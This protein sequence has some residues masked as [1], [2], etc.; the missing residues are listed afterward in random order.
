[1]QRYLKEKNHLPYLYVVLSWAAGQLLGDGYNIK[2]KE[3][4]KNDKIT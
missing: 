2:V 4:K 3:M 1:M